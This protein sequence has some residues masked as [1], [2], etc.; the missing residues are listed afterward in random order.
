MVMLRVLPPVF[1]P[2]FYLLQ[3]RFYLGGKTRN[4][5]IQLV[6]PQCC[7]TSCTF[8]VTPFFGIFTGLYWHLYLARTIFRFVVVQF[9]QLLIVSHFVWIWYAY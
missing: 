5:V 1:K 3:D 9:F 4:I 2:A 8:L 7:K 6:L